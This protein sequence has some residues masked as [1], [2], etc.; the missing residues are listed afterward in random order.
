MRPFLFILAIS[1][2]AVGCGRS[3]EPQQ[4]GGESSGRAALSRDSLRLLYQEFLAAR[5]DPMPTYQAKGE[6]KLYPVDEAPLD[7]S[8]FVFREQFRQA[9]AR[10]DVFYLLDVAAKDISVSF[11]EQSGF[12]DFVTIW[13]LGSNQPDTLEIWSVLERILAGGGA[14][15][16]SRKAFSAPYIYATWP[17]AYDAFDY[18]AITGSGVR[19]RAEPNL[20][21]RIM[22][23]ISH[24]IVLVLSESLPEEIDGEI[25]P[26]VQ[27]E[28]LDGIQGYVFGKFIA[29]PVGYRAGFRRAGNGEWYMMFL[30]AGD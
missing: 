15:S 4:T 7:T 19:L 14:F 20:S 17:E 30:V 10:K 22:K 2:L 18:G 21:S 11:G 23:T 25:Y 29:Y 5:A 12:A 3:G 24:D 26:W 27:V 8:F 9:I 16:E 1:L 28:T 13:G 6:G